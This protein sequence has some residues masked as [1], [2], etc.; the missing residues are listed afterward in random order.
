MYI[1]MSNKTGKWFDFSAMMP[2]LP[3]AECAGAEQKDVNGTVLYTA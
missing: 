3:T 1:H 2:E